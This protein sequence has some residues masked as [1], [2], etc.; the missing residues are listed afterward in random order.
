MVTLEV[1]MT[2]MTTMMMT[3]I[4]PRN[5]RGNPKVRLN[6]RTKGLSR[7][8]FRVPPRRRRLRRSLCRSSHLSLPCRHGPFNWLRTWFLLVERTTARKLIG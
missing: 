4:A 7:S 5:N 3:M 2:R 6:F 1:M 8:L